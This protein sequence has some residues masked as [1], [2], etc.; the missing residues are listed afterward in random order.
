MRNTLLVN[1]V[2]KQKKK[3]MPDNR[4]PLLAH[5]NNG[6]LIEMVDNSLLSQPVGLV[7]P[8]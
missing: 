1:K 2:E 6:P 3:H 5:W 7:G 4:P 8:Y